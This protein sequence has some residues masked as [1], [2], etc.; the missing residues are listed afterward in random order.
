M[1]NP[2]RVLHLGTAQCEICGGRFEKHHGRQ[3]YCTNECAV[4]AARRR[5]LSWGRAHPRPRRQPRDIVC[6]KCGQTFSGKGRQAI[7]PDCLHSLPECR[8]YAEA[9]SERFAV[10]QEDE[11]KGGETE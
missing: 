7:C 5:H 2:A 10:P 9:R 1:S 8:R 4:K 6:I 3:K 11:E